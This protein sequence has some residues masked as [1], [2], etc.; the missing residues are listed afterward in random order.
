MNY[1]NFSKTFI[2]T[3]KTQFLNKMKPKSYKTNDN[4]KVLIRE[5]KQ[6][7]TKEKTQTWKA[8]ANYLDKPIRKTKPINISRINKFAKDNETI[9]IPTKVLGNTNLT[10]N[11][12]IAAYSFSTSAKNK[13]KDK[14]SIQDLMKKNPKGKNIRI[15]I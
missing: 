11:V 7:S 3:L 13:I 1:L 6:L 10:K 12:S 9:V 4:L 5:L 14:M 2:N 15:M 8:V